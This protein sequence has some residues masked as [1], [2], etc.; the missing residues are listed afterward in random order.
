MIMALMFKGNNKIWVELR[1][2]SRIK[3]NPWQNLSERQARMTCLHMKHRLWAADSSVLHSQNDNTIDWWQTK[4]NSELWLSLL[5]PFLLKF[6][7]SSGWL[8][9]ENNKQMRQGFFHLVP[10]KLRLYMSVKN[11]SKQ[12]QISRL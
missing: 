7:L 1:N 12:I 4:F 6:L 9:S 5:F 10:S 3:E 2:G 8:T 11:H